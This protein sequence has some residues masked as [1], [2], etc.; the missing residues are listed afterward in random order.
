MSR[1]VKI[2]DEITPVVLEDV[3]EVLE[4]HAAPMADER[5][6]IGSWNGLKRWQCSRCPWD[7]LQGEESFMS[8]FESV[9]EPKTVPAP[10]P[11]VLYIEDR[12]G[13][14]RLSQEGV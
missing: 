6:T 8:H 2:V 10:A 13:N 11:P 14:V 3:Q 4:E 12:F 7:T 9:H 5:Y 1:K